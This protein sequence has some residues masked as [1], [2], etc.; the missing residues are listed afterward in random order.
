MSLDRPEE[1]DQSQVPDESS[2]CR[3]G[4]AYIFLRAAI[5]MGPRFT[6]QAYLP[7]HGGFKTVTNTNTANGTLRFEEGDKKYE[8]DDSDFIYF[9]RKIVD[10]LGL[11]VEDLK[12][13]QTE[14]FEPDKSG[15]FNRISDEVLRMV[16]N[17]NPPTP[18][19]IDKKTG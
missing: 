15:T 12:D 14:K 10:I 4:K 1:N 9:N 2:Q 6:A 17:E 7:D 16:E 11:K 3:F 13:L 8:P 18:W 5:Q 19:N